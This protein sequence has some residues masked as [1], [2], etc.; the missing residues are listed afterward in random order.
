MLRFDL[1]LP[2]RSRTRSLATAA[3]LLVACPSAEP[4]PI[5]AEPT[6]SPQLPGAFFCLDRDGDGATPCG[7]DCDDGD[8]AIGPTVE[9]TLDGIDNDCDGLLDD[10]ALEP[11]PAPSRLE[12]V[13]SLGADLVDVAVGG[14]ELWVAW[15]TGGE[16]SLYAARWNGA[17]WDYTLA[18][19]TWMLPGWIQ[20]TVNEAGEPK[21]F[22]SNENGVLMRV[23]WDGESWPCDDMDL[24]AGGAGRPFVVEREDGYLVGY[25]SSAGAVRVWEGPAVGGAWTELSAV[26]GDS[27][28]NA[29][30]FGEG[31][32]SWVQ[33]GELVV[34]VKEGEWLVEATGIPAVE[35]GLCLADPCPTL[36]AHALIAGDDLGIAVNGQVAW[37]S[38]GWV[39]AG[40]AFE[41]G[42]ASGRDRWFLDA[43]GVLRHRSIDNNEL[44]RRHWVDGLVVSERLPL[45][46]DA[47]VTQVNYAEGHWVGRTEDG[48]VWVAF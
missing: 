28:V 27:M 15:F 14:G 9:D 39:L 42:L 19:Q 1:M 3:L 8:A 33:D 5:H 24:E 6:P 40:A 37:R 48:E 21:A 31:A 34:A 46:E 16:G 43:G 22:L 44:V 11:L 2:L 23:N 45:F 10:D 47:P 26:A 12:L 13:G 41:E 17:A 35:E 7:E 18:I 36:G 29:A 38:E 25:R 32:V 20:L 4:E 30:D